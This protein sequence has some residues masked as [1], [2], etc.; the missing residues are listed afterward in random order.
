MRGTQTVGFNGSLSR[1]IWTCSQES[2]QKKDPQVKSQKLEEYPFEGVRGLVSLTERLEQFWKTFPNNLSPEECW[3]WPGA[4]AS[5]GSGV[6]S[7]N[8][9]QWK[10]H[11]LAWCIYNGEI[12]DG[13][14]VVH[15][16]ACGAQ[17]C[18]NPKHLLMEPIPVGVAI[19]PKRQSRYIRKTEYVKRTVKHDFSGYAST[20]RR[21]RSH[22]LATS[23]GSFWANIV[24]GESPDD[25]WGW[26]AA[27]HIQGYGLHRVCGDQWRAN[28]ISW[29]IHFGPIPPNCD[30]L[31]SCDN[32]PCCNP[33]H[34]RLG[35]AKENIRES[36][37]KGRHAS[38]GSNN[39]QAKLTEEKV[40]EMRRLHRVEGVKLMEIA[41]RFGVSKATASMA[42]SGRTWS[43]LPLL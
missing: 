39:P 2:T 10:V 11:R 38:C 31:H 43:Y 7:I 36:V 22:D 16:F 4:K 32:P 15:S 8:S 19:A 5:D 17:L 35:D 33:R 26:S 41:A 18:C 24:K 28:R 13:M 23:L 1:L 25:C 12:P 40:L 29:V 3:L 27:S 9:V 34:L 42:I 6:F 37:E 20:I 14:R 21:G 30:I